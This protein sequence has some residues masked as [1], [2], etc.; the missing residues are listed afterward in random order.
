LKQQSNFRSNREV[1]PKRLEQTEILDQF[2]AVS[3]AEQLCI[4]NHS[5]FQEIHPIEFLNEIWKKDN[6]SSASFKHFVN[7]FDVESYWVVTE[8][9]VNAKSARDKIKVLCKFISVAHVIYH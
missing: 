8:L 9:C 4:H 3:I 1:H 2:D 5:L 6:R 7:R